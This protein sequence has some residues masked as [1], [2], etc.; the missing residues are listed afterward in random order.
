MLVTWDVVGLYNNILH[1][2]G[3]GSLEEALDGRS[4]PEVPTDYL[5]KLMETILKNNIFNFHDEL[6]K[7]EVGCAMGTKPAPAYADVFMARRIDENIL[8]L[9]EK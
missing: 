4:N 9:A 2:E 8:S 6:W 1:E 5:I 3:L 7:Q